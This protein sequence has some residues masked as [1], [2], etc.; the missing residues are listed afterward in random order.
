V[1]RNVAEGLTPTVQWHELDDAVA[2]GAA[3]LDVRSPG[4]HR[5]G[6]IP[7]AVLVPLDELRDRLDEVP[8]DVPLVVCCAVG[9]RGHTAVQ[10]LRQH[11]FADVRNLDGGYATW[12][13]GT[14]P[15][16]HG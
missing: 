2:G 16:V 4:E 6:A 14:R 11:G 8:R 3:V 10:L 5:R 15:H 1:D 13:M 12:V 9:V 7:G